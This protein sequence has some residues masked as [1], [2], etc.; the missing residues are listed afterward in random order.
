MLCICTHDT[1]MYLVLIAYKTLQPVVNI[2]PVNIQ[3][4]FTPYNP[5]CAT[6][7]SPTFKQHFA[8][9]NLKLMCNM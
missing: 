6:R 8:H 3:Q 4:L 9:A 2:L 7:Q 1:K 5:I